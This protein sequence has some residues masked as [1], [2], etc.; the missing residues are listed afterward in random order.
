MKVEIVEQISTLG[1]QPSLL[2]EY[3]Q[4]CFIP[5]IPGRVGARLRFH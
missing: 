5:T 4:Q 3:H 1:E 2:L